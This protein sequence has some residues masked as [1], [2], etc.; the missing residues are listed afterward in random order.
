MSTTDQRVVTTYDAIRVSTIVAP[1][2]VEGTLSVTDDVITRGIFFVPEDPVFTEVNGFLSRMVDVDP[3]DPLF[4]K[5]S[6]LVF[7]CLPTGEGTPYERI[8]FA[9]ADPLASPTNPAICVPDFPTTGPINPDAEGVGLVGYDALG[10]FRP[11]SLQSIITVNCEALVDSAECVTSLGTAI[12]N[13]AAG[14]EVPGPLNELFCTRVGECI[15]DLGDEI[16]GALNCQDVNLGALSYTS[17]AMGP[18]VA[19][20]APVEEPLAAKSLAKRKSKVSALQ[21][22]P[23]TDVPGMAWF[24]VFGDTETPEVEDATT[25][26]TVNLENTTA[27]VITPNPSFASL[28]NQPIYTFTPGDFKSYKIVLH[29]ALRSV[30]LATIPALIQVTGFPEI[31]APIELDIFV[32]GEA[33]AFEY[34]Y[35]VN[36]TGG[37]PDVIVL[38]GNNATTVTVPY[39]AEQVGEA[40]EEATGSKTIGTAVA[41]AVALLPSLPPTAPSL[42]YVADA[43]G[44]VTFYVSGA[45]PESDITTKVDVTRAPMTEVVPLVDDSE[46]LKIKSKK[47]MRKKLSKLSSMKKASSQVKEVKVPVVKK[48]APKIKAGKAKVPVVKKVLPKAPV[49]PDE[50]EFKEA[51]SAEKKQVRFLPK[52]F[53]KK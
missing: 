4:G 5:R 25:L 37:A 42:T 34:T 32:G 19:E 21:I 40:I 36:D 52:L 47:D 13:Q 14:G 24:S 41:T 8:I 45:L 2:T 20:E 38:E 53:G 18:C 50:K 15:P 46:F 17:L 39:I 48:A 9:C 51:K 1:T 43:S 6:E 26:L 11:F 29:V 44:S 3:L 31:T 27:P 28:V 12:L 16:V 23:D 35:L 22:P 49:K 30:L 7:V 33:S 10:C